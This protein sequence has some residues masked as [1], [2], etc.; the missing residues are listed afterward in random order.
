L[1]FGRQIQLGDGLEQQHRHREILRETH[2]AIDGDLG[3]HARASDDI[4]EAHHQ[5]HRQDDVEKRAHISLDHHAVMGGGDMVR[6][7]AQ[8]R[9]VIEVD[10]HIGQHALRPPDRAS[11]SSVSARWAWLG[12]GSVAQG[13]ADE[14]SQ[15]CRS[16]GQA[17]SGMVCTSGR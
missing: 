14:D 11:H 12:C 1:K 6:R 15:A 13:V 4:A 8:D 7:L 3:K 16:C 17:S 2:D 5:K 10:M 9:V